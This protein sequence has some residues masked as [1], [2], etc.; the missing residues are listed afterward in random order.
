MLV[1]VYAAAEVVGDAEVQ[2]PRAVGHDIDVIDCQAPL[3]MESLRGDPSPLPRQLLPA[4]FG[5]TVTAVPPQM[6]K[7]KTTGWKPLQGGRG[8]PLHY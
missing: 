1:L 3:Q 4:S 8:R 2:P 5:M 7:L 6:Y